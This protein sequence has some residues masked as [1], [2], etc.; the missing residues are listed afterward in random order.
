MLVCFTELLLSYITIHY[1]LVYYYLP[2]TGGAFLCELL[3][4]IKYV[5]KRKIRT[6]FQKNCSVIFIEL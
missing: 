5:R 2:V 4:E 6:A 1:L 3:Q